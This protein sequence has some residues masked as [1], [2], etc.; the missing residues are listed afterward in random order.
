MRAERGR[1]QRPDDE[2]S[3]RGDWYATF[4]LLDISGAISSS[5]LRRVVSSVGRLRRR[6]IGRSETAARGCQPAE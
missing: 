2:P 6:L 5:H 1:P 3:R 4:T